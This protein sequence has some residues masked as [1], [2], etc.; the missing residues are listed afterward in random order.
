[1]PVYRRNLIVISFT[2]FMVAAAWGQIIPLLPLFL[3]ELGVTKSI[4]L[5]SGLIFSTQALAAMIMQPY[6]G[7][8]GDRVGRKAMI[9][10]AGCALVVIYFLIGHCRT[11]WQLLA[12]RMLNGALTGFIPGSLALLA[13][14]TPDGL[15]GRYVATAQSASAIGGIT[16]PVFGTVL[17]ALFGLRWSFRVSGSIALLATTLVFFLVREER[18]PVPGPQTSLLADLRTTASLPAMPLV[19]GVAFLSAGVNPAIQAV[20]AL[21]LPNLAGKPPAWVYGSIYALPGVAFA[22]CAILWTWVAEKR[23]RRG[24]MAL[25]LAGS[26]FSLLLLGVI[27][28]IWLF[29]PV[30][31]ILG[32]FLAALAP[33]AAALMAEQVPAN[34]RGQAYGIWQGANTFGQFVMPL[35]AG[36]VG[37]SWGL[38]WVFVALATIMAGGAAVLVGKLRR[39]GR[40]VVSGEVHS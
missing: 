16:G 1:M 20:L 4:A 33:N 10:R 11:G 17:A 3:K 28:S 6:W 21:H 35:A 13:T 31:L 7:R 22:T 15:S 36:A 8:L 25:G 12:L 34:M 18:R 23:T 2:I 32:I 14:N 38:P 5:W 26:M 40:G 29:V 30:Y 9:L 37:A 24:V 19:L 39:R 27:Q